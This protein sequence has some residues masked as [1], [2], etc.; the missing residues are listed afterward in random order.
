MGSPVVFKGSRIL[1]LNE[2]GFVY[3]SGKINIYGTA[4]PEGVVAAPVGSEFNDTTNGIKYYKASG[5]GN[6]GWVEYAGNVPTMLYKGAIAVNTDFPL[7]ADVKNG[8]FYTIS[9]NVTDNAGVLYTNTGQSFTAGQEIAWNGVDWTLC[10]DQNEFRYFATVVDAE[11]ATGQD[12]WTCFVEATET[13]YRYES[14][15]GAYAD[16]NAHILSTGDA[17]NTRW[18]GIAGKYPVNNKFPLWVTGEIYAIGDI[19]IDN[20]NI[21]RCITAHTAGATFIGDRANWNRISYKIWTSAGTPGINNDDSDTAA[22]GI[23]FEVGDSW[24]NTTNG[25]VFYCTDNS[26]G[27]AT[28]EPIVE[29]L[30]TPLRTGALDIT[31]GNEDT[32]TSLYQV[33][34]LTYAR[35]VKVN[36]CNRNNAIVSVRI[37][38]VDGAIG[39][40]SNE[41]YIFYDTLLQPY[42]TK[43][44]NIDGMI[45]TD[46]ILVRSDT[47]SVNF[48]AF[49]E[50][51]T[52]DDGTKRLGATTVAAATDTALYV[53]TGDVKNISIVACNR[54][55][56]NTATIRI[57]V[58]DGALGTWAD[59]DNIIYEDILLEGE[60]KIYEIDTELANT[61]T[62]GVRS[63]DADVNFI[64]YGKEV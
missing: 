14:A 59:E 44:V 10:G 55:P 57:A 43:I 6:T 29:L 39:A 30:G 62:I 40:V 27:A 13:Y 8:W 49:S 58:I 1:C 32:D 42:E 17:G 24:F 28:W 31:A 23:Y 41:D 22:I 38:H 51:F 61:Y 46:S 34:A 7:I 48:S 26:T 54:D 11:A 47:A 2:G 52:L 25:Q 50:L 60:T 37:A 33:P 15:G 12:G 35:N 3:N 5:V 53:A 45:P 20:E 16:D 63:S 36:V 4:N 64:A 9:A 18:L 21:Y 56:S 19:V